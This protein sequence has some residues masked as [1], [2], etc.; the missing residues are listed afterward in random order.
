MECTPPVSNED[1]A[2]ARLERAVARFVY[3]TGSVTKIKKEAPPGAVI[4]RLCL[5]R[6]K[7]TDSNYAASCSRPFR[8]SLAS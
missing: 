7:R 6:P 5:F 8:S 2:C 3:P 1:V 4:K